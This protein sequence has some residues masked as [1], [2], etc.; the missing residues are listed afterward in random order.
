MFSKT[1]LTATILAAALVSAFAA[2]PVLE[3]TKR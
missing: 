1:V 2:E 3:L